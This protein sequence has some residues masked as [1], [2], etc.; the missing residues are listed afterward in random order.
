ML[1]ACV[2]APVLYGAG[3]ADFSFPPSV[4]PKGRGPLSALRL[5]SCLSAEVLLGRGLAPAGAPSRRISASHPCGPPAF[6]SPGRAFGSDLGVTLP[7]YAATG[8][9][10]T[11]SRLP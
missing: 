4:N 5:E 8:R 3:Y 6:Q 10:I 7:P 1:S 11:V 9:P 2:I